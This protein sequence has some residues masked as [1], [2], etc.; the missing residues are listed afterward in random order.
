[1]NYTAKQ[2]EI[3]DTLLNMGNGGTVDIEA[4]AADIL[5]AFRRLKEAKIPLRTMVRIPT[6]GYKGRN[7]H[8]ANITDGKAMAKVFAPFVSS[9]NEKLLK[10]GFDYG[11][12]GISASD[13]RMM[14]V[15]RIPHGLS[16][17]DALANGFVQPTYRWQMVAGDMCHDPYTLS[18][19]QL[20]V[21]VE[22]G[23]AIHGLIRAYADFARAYHHLDEDKCDRHLMMVIG[24]KYYNPIFVADLLDGLFRLGNSLVRIC[25]KNDFYGGI[26]GGPLN[27]FGMDAPMD[28]KGLVMPFRT[29]DDCCGLILPLDCSATAAA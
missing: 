12:N 28:S 23:S 3:A 16:D 27:L 7:I 25:E 22:K 17:E 13:G 26:G 24:G 15:C 14:L 10:P 20:M 18:N 1:M 9:Y 11:G 8:K 2:M 19:Y 21:D 4:D 29:W 5:A 6:T